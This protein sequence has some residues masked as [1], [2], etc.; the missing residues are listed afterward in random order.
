[1]KNAKVTVLIETYWNVNE[2]D[3]V[4]LKNSFSV[5]IE[6]YWNVN[7]GMNNNMQQQLAQ[8][9]IETYWNVNINAYNLIWNEWFRY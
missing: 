5:L 4:F 9:L 1:M 3:L 8:V 2:N 6:T 7:Y